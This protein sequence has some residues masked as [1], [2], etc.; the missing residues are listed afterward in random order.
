M[1]CVGIFIC[2]DKRDSVC[3]V[4]QK[5]GG[6][7]V[8][9][10]A[11]FCISR[12]LQVIFLLAGT[13]WSNDCEWNGEVSGTLFFCY[14][15]ANT[16]IKNF[17]VMFIDSSSTVRC[18]FKVMFIERQPNENWNNESALWF[19]FLISTVIYSFLENMRWCIKWQETQWKV[20]IVKI[21][22]YW[23]GKVTH[24]YFHWIHSP[25]FWEQKQSCWLLVLCFRWLGALS[26][27]C[28]WWRREQSYT[29][30]RPHTVKLE[31]LEIFL[32]LALL[33]NIYSFIHATHI[34]MCLILSKNVLS[35]F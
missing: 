25:L 35:P 9:C 33:F 31:W 30:V 22:V 19:Y 4:V 21:R 5:Q 18:I 34:L 3:S 2:P 15:K 11:H 26:S 17:C 6:S 7:L 8:K 27:V 28:R 16:R 32:L 20:K 13:A 10:I 1:K 23:Y 24:L 29:Y 14:R 12:F